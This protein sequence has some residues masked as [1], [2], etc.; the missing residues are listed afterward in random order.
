MEVRSDAEAIAASVDRPDEF[1]LIFDR[2]FAAVY[3][4]V[5]RRLGAD[6]GGDIASETFTRAFAQRARYRPET[7]T[8]LPWLLGIA[9]RLAANERRREA[10]QLRAYAK[11]ASDETVD[12]EVGDRGALADALG[13][14]EPRDR[15]ALLLF[16]W[17]DLSYAE[18]AEA[19]AIPVGTVRSR[20][21]RARSLMQA[22]LVEGGAQHA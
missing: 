1:V 9:N 21:N 3:R 7:P 14:I 11:A 19:L 4:F 18:V 13:R 22:A 2:H 6:A 15:D 5:A 20:I 12:L 16:A 17:A 10:R 8:A